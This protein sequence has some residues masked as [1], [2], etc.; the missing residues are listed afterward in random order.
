MMVLLEQ[1]LTLFVLAA[2]CFSTVML[3]IKHYKEIRK[4]KP[5]KRRRFP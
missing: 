5:K 3:G 2:T 4:K 1:L